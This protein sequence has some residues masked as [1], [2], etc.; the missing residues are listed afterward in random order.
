MNLTKSEL[1]EAAQESAAEL[2]LIRLAVVALGKL[3]LQDTSEHYLTAQERKEC[4]GTLQACVA[5][6]QEETS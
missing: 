1:L 4:M 5:T 2:L 6:I 3:V